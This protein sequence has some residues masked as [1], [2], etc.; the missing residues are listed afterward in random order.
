[1]TSTACGF[2]PVKDYFSFIVIV[3]ILS[4]VAISSG[5]SGISMG[6]ETDGNSEVVLFIKNFT[7]YIVGPCLWKQFFFHYFI[8]MT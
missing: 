8:I 1:M 3:L 7:L 5:S 6:S 2:V 4:F